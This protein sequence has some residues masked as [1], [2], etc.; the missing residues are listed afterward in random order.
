MH[1]ALSLWAWDA[2]P[3][4]AFPGLADVWSDG[5]NHDRGHWLNGRLEAVDLAY[6]ITE[7]CARAGLFAVDVGEVVGLVDGFLL[8]RPLSARDALES[9]LDA[10]AIDAVEREG[11]I[12][13]RNR[14]VSRSTALSPGQVVDGGGDMRCSAPPVRRKRTCRKPCVW[15]LSKRQGTFSGAVLKRR[16]GTSSNRE[17]VLSLPA[18]VNA[19]QAQARVDVLLEEAWAQRTTGQ[20]AL[21]P[22]WLAHE[23]GDV[24][25]ID[26]A[27][28]RL[29][30]IVDGAARKVDAVSHAAGVYA[31]LPVPPRGL[32]VHAVAVH[33]A[34][35]VVMMDL[36]LS[37]GPAETRPWIAAQAT[38]WPQK[39][40][41]RETGRQ[42]IIRLQ[43][44]C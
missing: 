18:A 39:S 15:A 37:P 21:P 13:F 5:A 23:P 2:R 11:A 34:P 19:A 3:Y 30:A 14:G 4:P 22:S 36:A 38:P 27:A 26:G 41:C 6:L 12:Y 33:G 44:A 25:S 42:W 43:P 29:T 9:L 35:D 17:I 1:R 32:S 31:P 28:F 8:D 16:I 7:I 10:F 24:L 20:F 40:G